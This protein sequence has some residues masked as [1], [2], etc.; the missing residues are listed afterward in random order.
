MPGWAISGWVC[1]ND[2]V[3]PVPHLI[4]PHAEASLA[5]HQRRDDMQILV[6]GPAQ[7]PRIHIPTAGQ[8]LIGVSLTPETMARFFNLH[9]PEWEQTVEQAPPMLIQA[10]EPALE[11][12]RT[13]PGAAALQIWID[14]LAKQVADD[15]TSQSVEHYVAAQM[16]A[17][18]GNLRVSCLNDEVELSSRHLRR[19][20]IDLMGITPK[21]FARQ[22]RLSKIM[23]RADQGPTPNW[24]GLAYETGYC[25]QSHFVRECRSLTALTPSQVHADRQMLRL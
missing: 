22:L 24:A 8:R 4:L 16:R 2:N 23:A 14:A 3:A 25:D 1:E 18:N 9:P 7:E 17:Q 20:F 11:A 5:V 12:M 6:C 21:T 19:R 15:A 13:L 10:L